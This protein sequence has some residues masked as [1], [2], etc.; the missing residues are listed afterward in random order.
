MKVALPEIDRILPDSAWQALMR[1]FV[2]SSYINTVNPERHAPYL[3]IPDDVIEYLHYLDFVKLRSPRTVNGYYLDLRGFFRFMMVQWNR[4]D[5]NTPPEKID[6][7]QITSNDIAGISKRDI[8]SYLEYVRNAN[9]G[10]KARARKLSAL[11][12][13]FGYMCTQ[14]NKIAQNPT[15]NVTLGAPKKAL[16]KYLTENESLSLLNN[17]QSDF[18][19]RD[20]CII[21]LFLNCGMRLAELVSINLSDFRDDTIRITGKGSK[22][23]LV[24]LND[25][26]LQALAH[27]RKARNA[28]PNLTDKNAL[29]VSKRTGKRLTA[30]R[31]EQIVARCLQSAGLSGRGFS[32]HKLRHTA[33]TLMYQGGVDML[34]LKEIL[35]HESV[36]TTQ[37]YTHINQQQLRDAVQAS[38]L[39]RQ[40]FI[41]KKS[42]DESS[43]QNDGDSTAQ[44]IK[45][46]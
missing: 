40:K 7:T 32:P 28:L 29:F 33:A 5:P 10:A 19:E 30:R 31:V 22:E 2:L 41:E 17:I 9:N 4:T 14:V 39:S 6:L 24:Y 25:A 44:R 16:P 11:K 43:D 42:S 45:D 8:F 18:Y 20:F 3:D 1:C 34:A 27:Y 15:E 37:I 21:T 12:G 13:F 38:P 36:S 23:R 46:S 35:G 26:C